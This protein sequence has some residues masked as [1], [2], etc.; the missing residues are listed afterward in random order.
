MTP[1]R[2]RRTWLDLLALLASSAAYALCFPPTS[3]HALAWIALVPF[4]AVIHDVGPGRALAYGLFWGMASSTGITDWLPPA[5]ALY[6]EQPLWLGI[7]I[8]LA[9]SASMVAVHFAVFALVSSI[10]ARR[11]PAA[12][13]LLTGAAWVVAELAR[14]RLLTGNP[15]GF[16]GCSQVVLQPGGLSGHDEIALRVMQVADLGGVYAPGFLI[17]L[18]NAVLVLVWRRF[19][20]GSFDAGVRVAAGSAVAVLLAA[21]AYGDVRI[22]SLDGQ[23]QSSTPIAIVQGNLD[24]GYRWNRSHYGK[25]LDAYLELTRKIIDESGPRLVFWPENAMTFFVDRRSDFRWTIAEVTEPAGVELV[26][27]GPRHEDVDGITRY[28]NSA[29]VLSPDGEV[30]GTYDKEHLLPFAEYFPF[31]SLE[32]LRRNFGGVAEITS[33]TRTGPLDTVAGPAAVA[34]CNE[35]M[36]PRIVRERVRAGAGYILNL[37][38]DGWMRSTE[39]A[40]HQLALAVARAIEHRRYLV[41]ASTSGPSAIV[42]PVGRVLTRTAPYEVGSLAGA[43]SARSDETFYSRRGDVFALAC[44]AVVLAVLIAGIRSRR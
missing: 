26:A 37:A 1:P 22:R 34:I 9:A 38:N 5:I 41:R 40:E 18:G 15:W 17:C 19:R 29:F 28:Y 13:P 27:G 21:L 12:W 36:F 16:L 42:D 31:G 44:L 6:Y 25:N 4:L 3:V 14:A 24:L 39:F 7:G 43:I 32:L 11:F 35:I 23:A 10:A 33:G 30:L 8:F 2:P 20:R